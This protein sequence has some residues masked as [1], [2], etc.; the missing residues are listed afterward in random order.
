MPL[1]EPLPLPDRAELARLLVRWAE[2]AEEEIADATGRGIERIMETA[3]DLERYS[4][5]AR[6]TVDRLA[7]KMKDQIPDP[8]PRAATPG[9]SFPSSHS[10]KAPP[11]VET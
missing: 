7:D 1:V 2:T 3:L 11:A 4:Q 9:R 5:S 6:E 10:R 8:A